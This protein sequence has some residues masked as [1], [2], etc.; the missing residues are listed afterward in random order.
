M[1]AAPPP[2]P[3]EET[4]AARRVCVAR[5][6]GAYGVRGEAR[7]LVFTEDPDAL[8][9]LGPFTDEAGARAFTL[10]ALRSHGEGFV[11]RFAEIAS[12]EDA[13]ALRNTDL[14]IP[15]DRLPALDEAETFYHADLIGLAVRAPEGDTLGKVV[16]VLNFGAGDI[17]DIAPAW[18]GA[19][20]MVPFTQA[21]VPAVDLAAGYLTLASR[22]LVPP[23]KPAKEG[24]GRAAKR[25]ATKRLAT[26]RRAAETG[27]G[28]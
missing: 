12:R 13:E 17:L 9:S 27:G 15:R 19:T 4:G 16:A 3:D 5:I 20:V 7:L 22:D 28:G 8:P 25:L 21:M 2:G 26:K 23:P 10:N 6:S 14:Y 11:A 1:T 18:G 24:A